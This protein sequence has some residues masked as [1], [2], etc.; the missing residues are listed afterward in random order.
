MKKG[1]LLV[2][3][4]G[5]LASAV[6]A[7]TLVVVTNGGGIYYPNYSGMAFTDA[8]G[9]YLFIGGSQGFVEI[10]Y[11]N[12]GYLRFPYQPASRTFSGVD[13]HGPFIAIVHET[14]VTIHRGGGGGRGNGY[15]GNR[16]VVSGGEIAYIYKSDPRSGIAP[17]EEW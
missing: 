7:D 15:P 6:R 4:L 11:R 8:N 17:A 1:W 14:L 13:R 10:F 2:V 9:N 16:T 3:V 5:L 12:G